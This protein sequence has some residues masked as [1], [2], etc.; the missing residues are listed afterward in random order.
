[1]R[2]TTECRAGDLGPTLDRQVF[3]SSVVRPGNPAI[4]EGHILS[5]GPHRSSLGAWPHA[6]PRSFY[7]F[8][9]CREFSTRAGDFSAHAAQIG[10]QSGN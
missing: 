2:L 5:P 4:R 7:G 6:T 1:V 9:P 3:A 10:P 8:R